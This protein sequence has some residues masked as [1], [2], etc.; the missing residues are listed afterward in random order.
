MPAKPKEFDSVIC[1]A[2]SLVISIDQM[3]RALESDR[4]A[5]IL[6]TWAEVKERALVLGH[7]ARRDGWGEYFDEFAK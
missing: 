3:Q 5:I 1:K 2:G 4:A 6:A 7:Q